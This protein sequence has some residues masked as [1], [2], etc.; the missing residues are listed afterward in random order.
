MSQE[1]ISR[2]RLF[3]G[4]FVTVAAM[5]LWLSGCRTNNPNIPTQKALDGEAWGKYPQ[6][7]VTQLELVKPGTTLRILRDVFDERDLIANGFHVDGLDDTLIYELVREELLPGQTS[8]AGADKG[9]WTANIISEAID[10]DPSLTRPGGHTLTVVGQVY[11]T[12]AIG[13]QVTDIPSGPTV[14]IA[15]S[16][17]PTSR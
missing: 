15:V 9:W 2:R 11:R 6:I 5:T 12:F 8:I 1:K 17:E 13:E 7:D 14:F 16:T 3:G 4:A 10:R